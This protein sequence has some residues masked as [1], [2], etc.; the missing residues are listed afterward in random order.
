M[1]CLKNGLPIRPM[2]IGIP[3][4]D[5]TDDGTL[6]LESDVIITSE[7]INPLFASFYLEARAGVL[8]DQVLDLVHNTD[9]ISQVGR[10][11]FQALDRSLFLSMR[12]MT[13]LGLSSCC[14]A[15]AITLRYAYVPG[16]YYSSN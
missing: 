3:N 2:G 10:L 8:L 1:I 16:I 4:P 12:H 15:I 6:R 14:E 7:V 9:I 13:Q 5:I 11:R